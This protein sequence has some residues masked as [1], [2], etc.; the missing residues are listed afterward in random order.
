MMP[1]MASPYDPYQPPAASLDVSPG[2]VSGPPAEVPAPVIALLAETR[3]WVKLLAVLF[4]I[5][6]GVA[7]VAVV[8]MGLLPAGRRMPFSVVAFIPLVVVLLLYIPPA[9]FLWR[10]AG[11]IRRLQAGG[12][13]GALQEALA[14]QKSFWKYVG[15]LVL[16]IVGIYVLAAVVGLIGAGVMRR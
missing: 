7:V 2:Q 14:S 3:P 6:I 9:L 1:L 16:V 11:N 13:L 12:G 4:F 15:V 8:V 5:S 10:Y